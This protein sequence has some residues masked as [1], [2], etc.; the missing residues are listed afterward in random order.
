[1]HIYSKKIKINESP[2]VDSIHISQITYINTYIHTVFFNVDISTRMTDIFMLPDLDSIHI[3]L[4]SKRF[5][6]PL[7]LYCFSPVISH[8]L[9]RRKKSKKRV[10]KERQK[11]KEKREKRGRK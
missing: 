5:L 2:D 6:P 1:M 4:L 9:Y 7:D 11:N 10:K 3:P 8:H